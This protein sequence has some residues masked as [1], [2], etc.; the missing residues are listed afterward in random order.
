MAT[1]HVTVLVPTYNH[2]ALLAETLDSILAQDFDHF[3]VV[4]SDDGSTDG[5]VEVAQ[6]YSERH[7]GKVRLLTVER[8]TGIAANFTRC[9]NA[10]TGELYAWCAGDDIMLPGKLRRQVAVMEEQ[11]D[12]VVSVHDAD[13][14]DSDSGRVLGR[15]GEMYNGRRGYLAGGVELLL[16]PGY[17]TLPSTMMIRSSARPAHGYDKRLRF[18]N[19]WLYDVE[20]LRNG[21]CVPINE[22]LL[23]YRRHA[24]NV[25]NSREAAQFGFEDALVALALIQARFPE[26]TRL[27]RRRRTAMLVASAL[28]ARARGERRRALAL[29]RSAL[30]D[31][32]PLDIV[33]SLLAF[34]RVRIGRARL[35]APAPAQ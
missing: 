9:V 32:G 35:G 10:V 6:G 16:R 18:A 30:A 2:A 24:G 1:S 26:L 31:G 19:E 27:V 21:R 23:R 12:P 15:F 14:F 20:T 28:D 34:A 11:P 13:V 17:V 22:V 8:N 7:P 5:T 3:D 29:A 25:T 33:T 4:V